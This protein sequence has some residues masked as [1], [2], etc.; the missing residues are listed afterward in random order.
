[1]NDVDVWSFSTVASSVSLFVSAPASGSLHPK[2][3]LLDST[4]NVV[5]NWLDPDS[6]SVSWTG[7]LNAGSYRLVVAS[8]GI[9]A[10]ATANNYGFD[11]GPYTITGTLLTS[12][13]LVAAPTGLTATAVSS[14][15]I[16]LAWTDN[17]GNETSYVVERST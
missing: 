2:I 13:N 15:Q 1:M 12:A 3:Q 14:T 9:S 10:L 5:V 7:S 11:V 4:G 8:H 16:N 6:L 17:A